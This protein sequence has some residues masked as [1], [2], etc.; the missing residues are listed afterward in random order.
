MRRQVVIIGD[1]SGKAARG[2]TRFFSAIAIV[3]ATPP[4]GASDPLAGRPAFA[5]GDQEPAKAARCGELRAMTASLAVPDYR[6]DLAIEGRLTGVGTDGAL[7]YLTMCS[8]PDIAVICVT[9]SDNGMKVGDLVGFGGGYTR[10]N[11]DQVMLD[12]C[13]ANRID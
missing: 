9:Y 3:F 4:A 11:T 8:L 7:W 10:L 6:I 12:P 5:L 13:L 1:V 2:L